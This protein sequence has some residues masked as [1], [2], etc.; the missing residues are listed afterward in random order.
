MT[1]AGS[2]GVSAAGRS[3]QHGSFT[4][5][6]RYDA[7]PAQVFK[8]W[9][10]PAA[11]ARW[12]R[13]PAEWKETRRELDFRPGGRE[14]LTGVWPGGRTSDFDARYHDIVPDRRIVYVY[15]MHVDTKR[16]SVSLATIEFEP[17]G[18][19]TRL[20]LTEQAAFLDGFE[21][22]GGRERGTREHLDRLDAALRTR[23]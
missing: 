7:T 17:A 23:A 19:G 13:G 2:E 12:F 15:D 11:K 14:R 22:G 1:R 16:I 6:R 10:D 9:A 20:I 8:A 21:D 18:A 4:I 5:E 3:A